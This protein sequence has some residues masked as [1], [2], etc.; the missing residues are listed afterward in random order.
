MLHI[1]ARVENAKW[2]PNISKLRVDSNS[3]FVLIIYYVLCNLGGSKD[4]GH[5]QPTSGWPMMPP[6]RYEAQSWKDINLLT[7]LTW[8]IENLKALA[9]NWVLA[10][11]SPWHYPIYGHQGR[12]VYLS[13][14]TPHRMCNTFLPYLRARS[15][16]N[17][18][19]AHSY[20]PHKF[21]SLY[22]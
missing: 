12:C 21:R 4:G 9:L 19:C 18:Y 22:K 20:L 13:P 15:L 16:A 8:I 14:P 10:L 11:E 1:W 5:C 6:Q 3:K 2:G 7:T 17:P